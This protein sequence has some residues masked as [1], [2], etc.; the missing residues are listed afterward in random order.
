MLIFLEIKSVHVEEGLGVEFNFFNFLLSLNTEII[1][2]QIT[3]KIPIIINVWEL[4]IFPSPKREVRVINIAPRLF[5]NTN[6]TPSTAAL[7]LIFCSWSK[8]I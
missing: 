6:P 2:R 1:Q 4:R 7:P 5:P 8:G 3:E